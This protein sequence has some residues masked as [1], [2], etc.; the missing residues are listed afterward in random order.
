[1]V[2][3]LNGRAI[4]LWQSKVG[5]QTPWT[6]AKGEL[7][8]YSSLPL[9][10]CCCSNTLLPTSRASIA[11][12]ILNIIRTLNGYSIH[13]LAC[14]KDHSSRACSLL[15]LRLLLR[16]YKKKQAKYHKCRIID[17]T[18]EN[19]LMDL[20]CCVTPAFHLTLLISV[21]HYLQGEYE[22]SKWRVIITD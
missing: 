4:L 21:F 5:V 2:V 17:R 7:H 18:Q 1:M 3:L 22:G 9:G 6:S 19:M 8:C 20:P 12:Y 10:N 11:N 16:Y 15:S 14:T 13:G